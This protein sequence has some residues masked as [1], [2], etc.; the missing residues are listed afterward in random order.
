MFRYVMWSLL[1]V[2]FLLPL[3][4]A[5]ANDAG[6]IEFN[7]DIRPILAEHCLHCHGP[8]SANRQ[9]DLRL[10]VEN[11]AKANAIEPGSPATSELILR[12]TSTDPDLRMPP[13]DSA[14]PLSVAQ[15]DMITRWIAAGAPY[16]SHWAFQPLQQS[17]PP[18]TLSA[19]TSVSPIDRYLL[20]KLQANQLDFSPTVNRYQLIRRA[21]FDLTGLPPTWDEVEAFVHDESTTAFAKVIDRL[22]ES[23]RYGE[24]WGRHWLDIARY[25]DTHGGA[26][27]GFTRFPFS[28]TY[29]DYVINAFN[30]DLP[31]DQFITE[32]LAADQLGRSDNDPSLAALGFLTV[33]MQFRNRHDVIDDQIDVVG[34]GLLGLTIA[35]ARCHDHKYDPIP[36]DDYYSLYATFASSE[37]PESLPI[38]GSPADSPELDQYHNELGQLETIYND[39][40]REQSDVMRHRLRMQLGLFLAELVKGTPEQDLSS[41]FLSYRTDDVRPIVL[42]RWRK[43]LAEMSPE[44]PVFGPW[45]QLFAIHQQS[46]EVF[47]TECAKRIAAWN[48]QIGDRTKLPAPHSLGANTPHWNVQVIDALQENQ[49][50]SML[51]VAEI[52]GQVFATAQRAWMEGLMA[53]AA[54]AATNGEVIPDEDAR[55]ATINSPSLRQLRRHLYAPGTPIAMPDDLAKQMLNRTVSDTLGGKAGAIHNLHLSAPGSPARSMV[56]AEDP[57]AGPFFVFE[58]GQP[59]QRGKQVHARFLTVLSAA[60]SKNFAPGQRRLDLARAITSDANPLTRRVIVNWVW[61]HHFGLGLVRSPDNFGMRGEPPTHPE[62]LDYLA[63]SLSEEDGWS[64]K[65]LHRRIMLTQAYQQGAHENPRSRMIDPDNRW[66][67]RMP[68][69]RLDMES[70]RD[71]MLLVAGELKSEMGG[72]PFDMMTETVVPKRSVY[73]FVNRDIVSNFASTFDGPNPNSCTAKRPDTIV[74]QQSLFALNSSFIQDRAAKLAERTDVPDATEDSQR[75]VCMYRIALSRSP[76]AAEIQTALDFVTS[77]TANSNPQNRWQQ[78][79][80]ALLASN[81]FVFLD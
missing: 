70:M 62:L 54:E 68:R 67:W 21:T 45:V 20:A 80:H 15:I 60:D 57:D 13:A 30:A 7:R 39:M 17:S 66:L 25:A 72:R 33:G 34:R 50:Q 59:L 27:I 29:R 41:A 40:A 75:I 1:V 23:P 53:A 9:A 58:R 74:P 79:A 18:E 77:S 51:E 71:A 42:N 49:P 63:A 12:I 3:C 78:L 56:L 26:A 48:E 4:P 38:V 6:P 64:L 14:K 11:D 65:Q 73:G 47:A 81:E 16:Q 76:S 10:D 22:L 44:D 31:L 32:Q 36:T 43:Y 52:Y 55:H 19:D 28:Y 46:P 24:R 5:T 69:M 8:D 61:R 37:S 2:P 35:C